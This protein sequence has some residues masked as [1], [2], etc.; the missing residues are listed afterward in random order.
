MELSNTQ[1]RSLEHLFL[2]QVR[3]PEVSRV[4]KYSHVTYLGRYSGQRY[5]PSQTSSYRYKTFE[6]R[7]FHM[8]GSCSS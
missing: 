4:R 6:Y 8:L 3:N 2:D 5:L 7:S 1:G